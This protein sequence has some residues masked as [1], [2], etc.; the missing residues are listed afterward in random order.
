LVKCEEK[1]QFVAHLHDVFLF[2]TQ[3]FITKTLASIPESAIRL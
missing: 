3:F 1:Q 2:G